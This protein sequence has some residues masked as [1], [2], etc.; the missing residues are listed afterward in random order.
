MLFATI[1][2]AGLVGYAAILEIVS[3]L[4]ADKLKYVLC[5]KEAALNTLDA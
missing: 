2:E 1:S 4:L 3:P 5:I